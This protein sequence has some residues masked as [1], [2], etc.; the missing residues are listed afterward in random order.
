[1]RAMALTEFGKQ[2][3][4]IVIEDPVPIDGEVILDV[5]ACGVCQTDLKV[6]AGIHPTSRQASLP[7]VPG[8]EI[9]GVVKEIGRNVKDWQ[10]GDRAVVYF[11][12]GC[13]LCRFCHTGQEPLCINLKHT[14]GFTLNGG[15]AEKVKVPA[16]NLVKISRD[17]PDQE[18]AIIPDAVAT[19]VHAVVD[20]AEVK[21]GERVLVIGAGGVGIHV[22]Q[23]AHLCG[24]Y[25]V[26]VDVDEHKLA[27]AR[28]LGADE[29]HVVNDKMVI[30]T[31][32]NKIVET[33]G[34]LPDNEELSEA[35]EKGGTIVVVG[36]KVGKLM[37]L[38][39]M[40]LV[41]EEYVI[42]GSRA[43]SF[44][45]LTVA[46]DLVEKGLIKPVVGAMY[47]FSEINDVLAQLEAG[48]ISGRAVL[49]GKNESA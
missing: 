35:L 37:A 41:S 24:A 12:I 36:Y 11:Y 5:K 3:E 16:R 46:V 30:G 17:V 1:M 29:T 32:V 7:L 44:T 49:C 9:V 20:R 48:E 39:I 21:V 25:T 47:S 10:P 4:A 31:R 43:S 42:K 40:E 38:G 33:S 15:F 26:V 18:A 23:V 14:I 34:A 28:Q 8:H 19:A 45:N 6:A 2:L 22:L 13:G 27:L